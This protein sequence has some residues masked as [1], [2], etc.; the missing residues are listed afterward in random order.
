MLLLLVIATATAT[1]TDAADPSNNTVTAAKTSRKTNLHLQNH[2]G[3][4]WYHWEAVQDSHFTNRG[5]NVVA[6]LSCDAH[7][8]ARK[9]SRQNLINTELD[10]NKHVRKETTHMNTGDC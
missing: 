2:L 1:T 9:D 10:S 6:G 5:L 7:K 4:V 3:R 8:R